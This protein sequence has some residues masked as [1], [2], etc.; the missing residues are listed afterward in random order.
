MAA[1][2]AC[3]YHADDLGFFLRVGLDLRAH[4]HAQHGQEGDGYRAVALGAGAV[5]GGIREE[6]AVAMAASA[7]TQNDLKV[8]AGYVYRTVK[9]TFVSFFLPKHS[10]DHLNI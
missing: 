5:R 1:L 4:G 7:A 8:D 2:A 6:E 9:K 10:D 3:Y